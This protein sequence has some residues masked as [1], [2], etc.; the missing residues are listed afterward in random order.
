MSKKILKINSRVRQSGESGATYVAELKRL[1]EHCGFAYRL[2]EMV[3]DRLVCGI[4]DPHI[5]LQELDLTY[6]SLIKRAFEI[7]QAMEPEVASHDIHDLQKQSILTPTVQHLQERRHT[8]RYT[9]YRCVGN[10]T[11][12]KCSF[13]SAE[14]RAC[15]KL[16]HIAKVYRSKSK[17]IP[18]ATMG[19]HKQTSI[20]SVVPNNTPPDP[21]LH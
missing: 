11:A 16:G 10:H 1:G 19:K 2:N 4:N 8:K 12:N 9:C 15:G 14:C 3:G 18:K 13:L 20:N 17:K 7:A 5:Q 21:P 6:K